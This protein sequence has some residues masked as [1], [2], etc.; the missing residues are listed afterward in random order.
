MASES[1]IV[2]LALL[3]VLGVGPSN[4]KRSVSALKE[5]KTLLDEYIGRSNEFTSGEVGWLASNFERMNACDNKAELNVRV[6][7]YLKANIGR[8]KTDAN[9]LMRLVRKMAAEDTD[10]D[11]DDRDESAECEHLMRLTMAALGSVLDDKVRCSEE[12][13][14]I[15][16]SADLM[17]SFRLSASSLTNGTNES[18][19]TVSTPLLDRMLRHFIDAHANECAKLYPTLAKQRLAQMEPTERRH[20]SA[21]FEIAKLASLIVERPKLYLELV[22]VGAERST[23]P[24]DYDKDVARFLA[25]RVSSVADSEGNSLRAADKRSLKGRFESALERYV[26]KPCKAYLDVMRPLVGPISY[27]MGSAPMDK[28]D[29]GNEIAF[30][31]VRNA[32]CRCVLARPKV[33][34]NEALRVLKS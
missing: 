10:D 6:E 26:L 16:R 28:R 21:I 11:R 24:N 29:F 25:S 15:L 13:E 32:I 18:T 17:T 9:E 27:D 7:A 33:F 8:G 31:M 12:S 19:S 30:L 3:C 4:C 20:F 2:V 22:F 5:E 14:H 34:A 1:L 23:K